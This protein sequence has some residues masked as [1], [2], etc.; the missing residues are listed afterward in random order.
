MD[1]IQVFTLSLGSSL[2]GMG[3]ILTTGNWSNWKNPPPSKNLEEAALI[4]GR[5][6]RRLHMSIALMG[7][8][9]AV[10]G[11]AFLGREKI[12][13]IYWY[14][15]IALALWMSLLAILDGGA[16]WSYVIRVRRR[17]EKQRE[18]ILSD[19]TERARQAALQTKSPSDPIDPPSNLTT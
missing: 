5:N 14:G 3:W 2:F 11:G 10:A 12:T 6:G 18:S 1:V 19:A 4:Q 17:L 13:A 15:V 9:M 16:T 8:G 7:L